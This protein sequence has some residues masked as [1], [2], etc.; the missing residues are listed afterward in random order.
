MGFLAN[1]LTFPR[2]LQLWPTETADAIGAPSFHS[3]DIGW[4]GHMLAK[5]LD[6]PWDRLGLLTVQ[7]S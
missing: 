3:H 1:R 2:C 7:E 6:L 4:A 5:S